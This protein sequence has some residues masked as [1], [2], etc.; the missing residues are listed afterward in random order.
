MYILT[1]E[2]TI[3]CQTAFTQ[4]L[5]HFYDVEGPTSKA[6]KIFVITKITTKGMV[7]DTFAKRFVTF[8]VFNF[9]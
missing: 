5:Y 6:H 8:D 4:G 3:E 2:C 1:Y 9:Y 7:Y